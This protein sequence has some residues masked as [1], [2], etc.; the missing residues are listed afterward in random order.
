MFDLFLAREEI[1]HF[2]HFATQSRMQPVTVSQVT[3]VQMVML[4]TFKIDIWQTYQR[5]STLNVLAKKKKKLKGF[6]LI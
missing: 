3:F 4:P 1:F 5:Q 2:F 6:V